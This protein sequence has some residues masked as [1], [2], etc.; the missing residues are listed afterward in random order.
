MNDEIQALTKNNTWTFTSLP[1]RKK[2]IGC[3]WLYKTKF[4]SDGSIERHN[5]RLVAQGFTQVEGINFVDAYSPTAK[6][7][8]VRLLLALASSLN[9]HLF[10]LD[11]HNAF[12]HGDLDEEYRRQWLGILSKV[13][14]SN[15][16]KQCATDHSL[17]IHKSNEISQPY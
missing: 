8:I 17:F 10:Q 9:L 3:K 4:N 12:L 14:L 6:L 7:I 2:A 15:N 11:V 5:V 1:P 16:F 13:L